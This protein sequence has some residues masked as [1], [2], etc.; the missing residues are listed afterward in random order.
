MTKINE[1]DQTHALLPPPTLPEAQTPLGYHAVAADLDVVK[2]GGEIMNLPGCYAYLGALA[3]DQE[4][5]GD[6]QPHVRQFV[7]TDLARAHGTVCID[8]EA[9]SLEKDHELGK[10]RY[11]LKRLVSDENVR[12]EK[13]LG[14]LEV[15][16]LFQDWRQG[17]TAEHQGQPF[18]AWLAYEADDRQLLNFL[19]WHNAEVH[20]YNTD[21]EIQQAVKARQERVIAGTEALFDEGYLHP[22]SRSQVMERVKNTKVY[23]M[24]LFD[25]AYTEARGYTI[26][27]KKEIF[28]L[29]QHLTDTKSKILEHEFGHKIVY[30]DERC[31][32]EVAADLVAGMIRTGSRDPVQAFLDV[33]SDANA[34]NAYAG[35]DVLVLAVLKRNPIAGTK[36]FLRYASAPPEQRDVLRQ[37]LNQAL[38]AGEGIDVIDTLTPILRKTLDK[39]LLTVLHQINGASGR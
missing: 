2:R 10:T 24:D 28:I 31:M 36:A 34:Q 13:Y 19:Q 6:W 7:R 26:K 33:I 35:L 38:K 39:D 15:P 27:D 18:V 23:T 32:D 14:E 17:Q 5:E 8:Y 21:P 30:G 9:A 4:V 22:D 37:E 29:P 3:K 12:A 16:Q 1:L 25:G 11:Q 20:R